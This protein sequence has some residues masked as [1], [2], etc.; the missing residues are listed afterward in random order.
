MI[1]KRHRKEFRR[2][3]L[4]VGCRIVWAVARIAAVR[5]MPV[6]AAVARIA[7]AV[8]AHKQVAVGQVAVWTHKLPVAVVRPVLLVQRAVAR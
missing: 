4:H 8:A 7:A 5:R 3:I 2:V 6:V 1:V